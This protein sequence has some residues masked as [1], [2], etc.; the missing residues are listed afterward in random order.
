M[1]LPLSIV[2]RQMKKVSVSLSDCLPAKLKK[3]K[4]NK[5]SNGYGRYNISTKNEFL[6][7]YFEIAIFRA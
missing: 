7:Y 2:I 5:L 4:G 3:K 1:K 6:N